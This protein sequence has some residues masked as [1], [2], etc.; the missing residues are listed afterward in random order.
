[1]VTAIWLEDESGAWSQQEPTE[2]ENEQALHD[3]V[4]QTPD[5]LPL[6]GGPRLTVI[7]REVAL[8]TSGYVDVLAMEEDGRPVV[9]EVKLSRNAESRRAV[10]SQA[11]SYAASLHGLTRQDFEAGL[12]KHLQGQS[13][14]DR[15]RENL[16]DESLT[17]SAF[18]ESLHS[19]LASGGFRVV[20]VLNEAPT[21][22]MNLVGY[23][24]AVTTGLSLDL[25]AVHSYRIGDHRI[26]IPQRV[27][28]EHRPEPSTSG[29]PGRS[30][31]TGH[32]E[33]GVEPFRSRIASSPAQYHE[34]FALM[35]DWAEDLTRAGVVT[36]ETY[37]GTSGSLVLLPR[38]VDEK[39]GLVSIWMN[40]DGSPAISFWR[41]VFERRAPQY[42]ARVEG[43]ISPKTL[44]QGTTSNRVTPELLGVLK[45]AYLAAAP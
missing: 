4:M 5:L 22:L 1:M 23:L 21:E 33:K 45:D 18:E 37:F 27:D 42:I 43:L 6:S 2:Y 16:Q 25:I 36:S 26:A 10:V 14:F 20:I 19:Y 11:L 34:T 39:V 35:A 41:S 15:L 8:R 17:E 31:A 24:E 13:L 40:P 32:T 30:T 28:P 9:I 12:S 44:G 3:M 7:G 38:L 29:S